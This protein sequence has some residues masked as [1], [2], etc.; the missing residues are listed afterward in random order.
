MLR[1]FPKN[2]KIETFKWSNDGSLLYTVPRLKYNR[3]EEVPVTLKNISNYVQEEVIEEKSGI[4]D[5]NSLFPTTEEKYM[6]STYIS[7]IYNMIEDMASWYEK[8]RDFLEAR[9]KPSIA[10]ELKKQSFHPFLSDEDSLKIV[11]VVRF[12]EKKEEG[13]IK[14]EEREVLNY[15]TILLNASLNRF[16]KASS[17]LYYEFEKA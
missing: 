16:S 6:Y 17:H 15:T 5:L 1:F 14:K 12:Y 9:D 4:I 10:K 2:Y 8:R 7:L 11:V 3:R 13:F